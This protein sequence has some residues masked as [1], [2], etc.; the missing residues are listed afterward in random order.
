M[1]GF[2]GELAMRFVGKM[3]DILRNRTPLL[4]YMN[5]DAE[6][7]P[8]APLSKI[9][10]Q[11]PGLKVASERT[12]GPFPPAASDTVIGAQEVTLGNVEGADFGF[13]SNEAQKYNLVDAKAKEMTACVDALIRKAN[14]SVWD[15]VKRV[16]YFSGTAGTSFFASNAKGLNTVN[17]QLYMRN[18]SVENNPDLRCVLFANEYENLIGCDEMR[19]AN[20]YGSTQPVQEGVIPFAAGFPIHRDQQAPLHTAGSITGTVGT[21]ANAVAVKTGTTPVVGATALECTTVA[22]TGACA[23]K[24]GDIVSIAGYSYA[25]TSDAT[26]ATAGGDVVLN[27]DRGLV[28]A[29]AAGDPVKLAT[30]WGTSYQSLAGD[31]TGVSVAWRLPIVDFGNGAKALGDHYEVIDEVTGI[32]FMLSFYPHYLGYKCEVTA[33]WGMKVTHA[34]KLHRIIGLATLN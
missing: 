2:N 22:S 27:I 1:N 33:L 24:A 9:L 13:T 14:A 32:P 23:L 8:A 17:R 30:G 16:P 26:Q 34:E 12:P 25:L 5:L 4:K 29:P 6:A 19:F 21:T 10:V 7:A 15:A 31:L 3:Q 18:V 11:V 28:A 20:R